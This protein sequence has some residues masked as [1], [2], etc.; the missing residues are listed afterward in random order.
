M[1]NASVDPILA[2]VHRIKDALSAEFGHDVS[3]LCRYLQEREVES[4]AAG[5]THLPLPS[6]RP[7]KRPRSP[8]IV[9]RLQ[10]IGK[11]SG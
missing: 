5:P 7:L 9:R 3:A 4:V 2:E 11:V 1:K 8:K 10:P 6:A